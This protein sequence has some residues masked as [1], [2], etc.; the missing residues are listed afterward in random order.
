MISGQFDNAILPS[1]CSIVISYDALNPGS[2]KHGLKMC[3]EFK[4]EF[5]RLNFNAIHLY[6]G[7]RN[8][9]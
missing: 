7:Y 3:L 6:F 1:G 2:S 4:K 9:N 5:Y 8:N